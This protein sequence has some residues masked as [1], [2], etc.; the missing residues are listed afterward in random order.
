LIE[1]RQ[2]ELGI[3]LKLGFSREQAENALVEAEGDLQGAVN[4]CYVIRQN[5]KKMMMEDP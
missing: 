3:V 4:I 1:S 2:R 5:Q